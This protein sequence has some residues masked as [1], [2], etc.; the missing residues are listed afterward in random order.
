MSAYTKHLK[1]MKMSY[2][3]HLYRAWTVAF[4]LIVHGL[5]PFIWEHKASEIINKK[6]A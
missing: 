4:I 5:F 2:F 1:D 3:S 6:P